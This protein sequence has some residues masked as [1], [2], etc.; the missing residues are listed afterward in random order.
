M[1]IAAEARRAEGQFRRLKVDIKQAK[2]SEISIW[3][4]YGRALFKTIGNI[5]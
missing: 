3:H 2:A 5:R 4:A 1:A